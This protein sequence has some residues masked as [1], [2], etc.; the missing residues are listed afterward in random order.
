M[1]LVKRTLSI[2]L[3]EALLLSPP[4]YAMCQMILLNPK[5]N[6]DRGMELLEEIFNNLL[7]VQNKVV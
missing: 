6:R 7:S 1:Y 5:Y 3:N 4:D 2:G